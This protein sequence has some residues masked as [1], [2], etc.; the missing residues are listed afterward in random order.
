[1]ESD[2]FADQVEERTGLT[3][4]EEADCVAL[5]ERAPIGRLVFLDDEGQP[6]ALPVNYRWHDDCVVFRTSEGQ[7]LIAA[8]INSRVTFEVDE[9]DPG[10]QTGMSVLVKGKAARVDDWAQAE[11]LE[12]LGLVP[13]ADQVW[14]PFWVRVEP[15][16]ITGRR[17]A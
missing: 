9:W 12:T 13:W 10:T 11:Q 8:V 7:K 4:V 17:I 5:L 2:D 15:V 14:K 1:M 6:L 16:E 3:V